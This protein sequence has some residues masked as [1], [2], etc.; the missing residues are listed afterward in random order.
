[1]GVEVVITGTGII[2][3]L[4]IGSAE[5]FDALC[6]GRCAITDDHGYALSDTNARRLALVKGFDPD[7]WL[8]GGTVR[9]MSRHAQ[10][11]AAA[12]RMAVQ[13]AGLD[14][15]EKLGHRAAVLC[16]AMIGAPGFV[17][18]YYHPI[19]AKGVPGAS[20]LLFGEGVPNAA[21]SHLSMSLGITGS[22]QTFLGNRDVGFE[23]LLLAMEMIRCG[24]CDMAL[25]AAAEEFHLVVAQIFEHLGLLCPPG[26]GIDRIEPFGATPSGV[27]LGEGAA[28]VL[29]E[30]AEHAAKRGARPRARLVAVES[31]A[32]PEHLEKLGETVQR[33]AIH[34]VID[35]AD[36]ERVRPPLVFSSACG[37]QLD[38]H[39]CNAVAQLGYAEPLTIASITGA[40]GESLATVPLTSLVA[41]VFSAQFRK[42]PPTLTSGVALP[43][44]VRC[45][46]SAEA[47]SADR[48]LVVASGLENTCLAALIESI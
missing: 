6:A 19:V 12:G 16:G 45:P 18:D 11:A 33:A 13:D 24:R 43:D 26:G 15:E 21:S 35:A 41:A 2:S 37:L 10:M 4:G 29:L 38:H 42:C 17:F 27:V 8:S 40:I 32:A 34:A 46:P 44:G 47:T 14:P 1:M 3:P 23:C 7:E 20:P 5:F 31:A 22:C 28:V 30:S 25:V 39:E 9:R 48:V 36:P